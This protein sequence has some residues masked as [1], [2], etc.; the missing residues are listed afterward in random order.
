MNAIRYRGYYYDVETGLYY[1]MSR[2]Y[3]PATGNPCRV[4]RPLT[5]QD[6]MRLPGE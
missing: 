4:I 3:D 2:Y 5:E 1:L 6:K